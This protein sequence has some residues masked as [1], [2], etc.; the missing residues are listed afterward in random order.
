MRSPRVLKTL[1]SSAKKFSLSNRRAR[2]NQ[3]IRTNHSR[4]ARLA[5]TPARTSSPTPC[6]PCLCALCVKIPFP[7]SLFIASF[8][9]E[10]RL[11]AQGAALF[12]GPE[13][14]S[15]L[16]HDWNQHLQ[17]NRRSGQGLSEKATN[18]IRFS[19]QTSS[20]RANDVS[21]GIS[22]TCFSRLTKL[23]LWAT[24]PLALSCE[25][26]VLRVRFFFLSPTAVIP[27]PF[28]AQAPP[29]VIS[30]Q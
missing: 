29:A 20:S 23:F 16:K 10:R 17:K 13:A 26:L 3:L 11:V 24:H 25:G 5:S 14:F 6:P 7:A 12:A 30:G 4:R 1:R 2:Q 27:R 18:W 28:V 22:P 19:R 21:R 9:P 8:A 15:C